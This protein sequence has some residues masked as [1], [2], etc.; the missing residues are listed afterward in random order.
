[1]V[2]M[3]KET[4]KFENYRQLLN[5]PKYRKGWNLSSAN[6]FGRLANGIGGH[7][8]SPTN[9]IKFIRR[10]PPTTNLVRFFSSF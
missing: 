2:V 9:T 1:M 7:T 3:D 4:G 6:E 10:S 5:H 8:K